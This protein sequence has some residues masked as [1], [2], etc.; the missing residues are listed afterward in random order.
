MKIVG[1]FWTSSLTNPFFCLSPHTTKLRP[2]SHTTRHQHPTD[3]SPVQ[4][5][6]GVEPEMPYQK[7]RNHLGRFG[8]GG[9]AHEIKISQ[10][11]GGQKARVVLASLAL[12]APH[13]LVLDEP[14][15]HLDIETIDALAEGLRN[16]DG[17]VVLVS[18]DARLICEAGCELWIVDNKTVTRFEGEFEEYRDQLL[19]E[20]EETAVKAEKALAAKLE[21]RAK[22]REAKLAAAKKRRAERV[23]KQPQEK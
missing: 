13:I 15:N 17:G 23:A 11:S 7:I 16:F 18:H 3:Q 10:C 14:T 8:L 6:Q 5:L 12:E 19:E 1:F 20:I 2:F 21:A 4:Y 9:H 22:E